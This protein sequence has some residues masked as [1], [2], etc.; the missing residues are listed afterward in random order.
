VLIQPFHRRSAQ[1][2]R[3]R[4]RRRR[5]CLSNITMALIHGLCCHSYGRQPEDHHQSI[6]ATTITAG[7][8]VAAAA[9]A[10]GSS[11]G[12]VEQVEHGTGCG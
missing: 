9:K 6:I 12:R 1:D 11:Q 5:N 8:D 2:S 3:R 10:R 7:A 4:R